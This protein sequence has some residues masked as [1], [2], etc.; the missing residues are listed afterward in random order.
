[1]DKIMAK[2]YILNHWSEYNL[3]LKS[4][5]EMLAL[6]NILQANDETLDSLHDVCLN[7]FMEFADIIGRWESDAD[8]VQSL[9][10]FN[11][12]FT[13]SEFIDFILEQIEEIRADGEDPAEVIGE[14][15]NGNTGDIFIIRT[16]DG[17]V[18]R[19]YY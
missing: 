18:R 17:Y 15:T 1:M 13:E 4:R 9:Y 14:W 6:L 19:V 10:Q 8:V 12:F 7:G 2:D 5:Q 16:E 3:G 11:D